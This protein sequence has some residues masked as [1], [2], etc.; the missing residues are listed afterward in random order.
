MKEGS[1]EVTRR[2]VETAV[3]VPIA[4]WR[5]LRSVATPRLKDLL[6]TPEERTDDL[7]PPH[8]AERL[9]PPPNFE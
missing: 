3:L 9:H 8:T 1:Q 5:R 2:G 6:L 7:T 4:E